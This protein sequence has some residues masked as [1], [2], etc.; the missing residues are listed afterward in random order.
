MNFAFPSN[1]FNSINLNSPAS[2]LADTYGLDKSK[3]IAP[4]IRRL[5]FNAAPKD[6]T[7]L[8]LLMMKQPDIEKDFEFIYFEIPY[9]R[10]SAI[11]PA[12]GSGIVAGTSQIV[13]ITNPDAVSPDLML[14]H[15]STE[16]KVIVKDVSP[17]GYTMTIEAAIGESLPA[18]TSGL[19]YVFPVHASVDGDLSSKITQMTRAGKI[20]ERTN[21]VQMFA[22]GTFFGRVER[23][24]YEQNGTTD[25]MDKNR[26]TMFTEYRIDNSNSYWNGTRGL[27]TTSQG[28]RAYLM[29]GIVPIMKRAG[30]LQ[31]SCTAS[32][33]YTALVTASYETRFNGDVETRYIYGAH[34]HINKIAEILKLPLMRF[35]AKG[36][37]GMEIPLQYVE[38][39]GERWVFVPMQ[40][41]EQKSNS[42]P[43]SW[44]NQLIMLNPDSI[45]PVMTFP[46]ALRKLQGRDVANPTN[47]NNFD[48]EWIEGTLSIKMNNPLNAALITIN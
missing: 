23:Y 30:S 6:Y 48:I 46:E 8:K 5:I 37:N 18:L 47:M 29:D 43:A 32:Q 11:T 40:R 14:I 4:R 15:P 12:L 13:P 39:T 41:W 27:I 28:Q 19:T 22:R 44:E 10:Q 2:N 17:T 31:I 24:K 1:Q 16:Q 34:K 20:I 36:D 26:E 7:D 42:F 33:L 38:I 25:Y 9:Q 3:L 35:T 21:Y 45:T